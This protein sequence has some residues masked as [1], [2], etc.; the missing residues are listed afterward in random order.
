MEQ[1]GQPCPSGRGVLPARSPRIPACGTQ[2]PQSKGAKGRASFETRSHHLSSEWPQTCP[3]PASNVSKMEG[4]E[5]GRKVCAPQQ[6]IAN[7]MC[8]WALYGDNFQVQSLLVLEGV[9]PEGPF[10]SR[11]TE[12]RVRA[13]RSLLYGRQ[14]TPTE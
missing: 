8:T 1:P 7:S 10:S 14:L 6:P 2:D 11:A 12:A 5:S 4:R 13:N 9:T 3:V